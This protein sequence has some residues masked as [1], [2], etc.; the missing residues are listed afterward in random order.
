MNRVK[1]RGG[2]TDRQTDRENERVCRDKLNKK[3]LE[4]I[5]G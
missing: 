5:L 4:V 3:V 2:Q 1:K